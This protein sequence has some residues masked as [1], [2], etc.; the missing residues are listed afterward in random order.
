M[1]AA[2]LYLIMLLTA[3]GYCMG[4]SQAADENKLVRVNP[5]G[6]SRLEAKANRK[7]IRVVISTYRVDFGNR[8]PTPPPTGEARTNCTYSRVPCS[9]VSNLR[10]WVAGKKLFVPRS[11]FADSTD[12][13]NMSVTSK[14]GVNVLTLIGGDASESYTLRV[15]FGA[16]RVKKR[17]LYDLESNT[18]VQVTT[19]LQPPVLN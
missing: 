17:E 18:L 14:A 8:N 7:S 6:D 4:S 12:I 11:V 5:N 2:F 16:A 15:F 1:K 13:G 19:Y 9:Q 3:H 10:I